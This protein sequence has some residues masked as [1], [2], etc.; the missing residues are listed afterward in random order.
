LGFLGSSSTPV[1]D[2]ND[3]G[4]IEIE[5]RLKNKD[6]LWATNSD[7]AGTAHTLVNPSYV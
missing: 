4:V 2:I 7:N 5:I 6:I 1:I 3:T